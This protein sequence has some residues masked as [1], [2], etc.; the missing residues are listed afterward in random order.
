M[1][2]KGGWTYMMA[3]RP[4]GMIYV[5]VTAYLAARVAQHR[6]DRGSHYCRK[7]GIKTLVFAEAHGS[8]HDA[9]VRENA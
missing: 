9:I 7:Y 3:S 8:I 6:Q 1:K 2:M 5:G 4:H